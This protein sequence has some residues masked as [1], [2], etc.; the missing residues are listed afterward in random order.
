VASDKSRSF[1][2]LNLGV[3]QFLILQCSSE[4]EGKVGAS[5]FSG[6]SPTVMP[7]CFSFLLCCYLEIVVPSC[8][9]DTKQ[10]PFPKGELAGACKQNEGTV[11]LFTFLFLFRSQNGT[12][13]VLHKNQSF[14]FC[15]WTI[16]SESAL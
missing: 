4:A 12:T 15:P 6:F 1:P 9:T 3:Q 10:C 13:G 7:R 14:C 5:L 2:E 11:Y 8:Q 16:T